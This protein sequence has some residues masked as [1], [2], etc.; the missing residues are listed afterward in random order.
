MK[1]ILRIAYELY[2]ALMLDSVHTLRYKQY[3]GRKKEK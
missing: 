3:E 1:E 2:K